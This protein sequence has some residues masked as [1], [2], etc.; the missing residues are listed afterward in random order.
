[1]K[2]DFYVASVMTY[3]PFMVWVFPKAYDEAFAEG[4]VAQFMF[5]HFIINFVASFIIRKCFK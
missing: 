4:T 3:V 1:M 2:I 5:Y